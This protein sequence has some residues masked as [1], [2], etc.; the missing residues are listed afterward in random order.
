MK[1]FLIAGGAILVASTA[2]AGD[3][4]SI[5]EQIEQQKAKLA[6]TR[7]EIEEY[8]VEHGFVKGD[9]DELAAL[10][11]DDDANIQKLVAYIEHAQQMNCSDG[12]T[13]KQR[14]VLC[15]RTIEYAFCYRPNN[16]TEC[17]LLPVRPCDRRP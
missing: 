7:N 1:A 16:A 5:A 2:Q 13:Q 17:R 12:A 14:S 4:A 15:N 9:P 10:K 8:I 11:R 6:A 3:C